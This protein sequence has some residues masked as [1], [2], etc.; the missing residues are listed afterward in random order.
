[1]TEV[2]N[3]RTSR[4]LQ[5]RRAPRR[6][7]RRVP[8]PRRMKCMKQDTGVF[9]PYTQGLWGSLIANFSYTV[10]LTRITNGTLEYQ[11]GNDCRPIAQA[12]KG[13]F[14]IYQ[15][16][17]TICTYRFIGLT[18]HS[19]YITVPNEPQLNVLYNLINPVTILTGPTMR[20]QDQSVYKFTVWHDSFITN[21]THN[22]CQSQARKVQVQVPATQ[23]C[24]YAMIVMVT[25]VLA[26]K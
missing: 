13:E 12:T 10:P 1:M 6:F 3:Y 2:I 16:V 5:S 19:P 25:V 20:A 23:L 22:G 18:S 7:Q 14:I 21:D 4:R 24:Y 15:E 8:L 11:R 9:N 26:S 17:N